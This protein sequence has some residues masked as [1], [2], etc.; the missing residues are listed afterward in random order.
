MEA[1]QGTGSVNRINFIEVQAEPE[2]PAGNPLE[3]SGLSCPDLYARHW[4][5]ACEA[6]GV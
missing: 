5:P 6:A 2:Y 1:R 3:S 4:L